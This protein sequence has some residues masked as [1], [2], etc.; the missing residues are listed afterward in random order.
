[1]H[2]NWWH[3][4]GEWM[5]KV[6]METLTDWTLVHPPFRLT[7]TLRTKWNSL[8]ETC[9]YLCLLNTFK[10]KYFKVSIASISKFASTLPTHAPFRKFCLH[11]V[12]HFHSSVLF[13]VLQIACLHFSTNWC[14]K[15]I[16]LVIITYRMNG[17]NREKSSLEVRDTS[18]TAIVF[19]EKRMG[20]EHHGECDL[21]RNT[22]SLG[23]LYFMIDPWAI[24]KQQRTGI[25]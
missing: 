15:K 7:Q 14:S 21:T 22:A 25:Y 8:W 24:T 1:M 4:G 18:A 9:P 16:A 10:P 23:A 13:Y 12:S 5:S 17:E 2:P 20:K 6:L 3:G 11:G 19:S